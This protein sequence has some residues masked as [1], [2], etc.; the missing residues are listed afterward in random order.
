MEKAMNKSASILLLSALRIYSDVFCMLVFSLCRIGLWPVQRAKRA[1]GAWTAQSPILQRRNMRPY[2]RMGVLSALAA[3][4]LMAQTPP[5]P[6]RI[7]RALE[8]LEQGQPVYY[9]GGSGGYEQGK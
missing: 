3:S 9:A 5:K 4:A 6:K 1:A 8:M 2:F 7:N